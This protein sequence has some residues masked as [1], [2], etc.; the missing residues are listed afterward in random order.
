M[1]VKIHKQA[2]VETHAVFQMSIR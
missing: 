1:K 2:P